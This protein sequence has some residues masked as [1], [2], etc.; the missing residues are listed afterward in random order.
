MAN[1]FFMVW[2][3]GNR[4]P[5]YKHN[6]EVE[7][8]N[9]ARRLAEANPNKHFYVLEARVRYEG[10]ICVSSVTCNQSNDEKPHD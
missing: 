10:V 7:A 9:E 4:A 3:E 6:T 1:K 8:C 5:N 2:C